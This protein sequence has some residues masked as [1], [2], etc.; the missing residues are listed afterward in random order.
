MINT[1]MAI[2]DETATAIAYPR[3]ARRLQAALLDAFILVIPL[4]FGLGTVLSGFDFSGGLKAALFASAVL[5]LEPGLVC[6]TGGTIGHH[7]L[8]LRIQDK[9]TG[10]NLNPFFAFIRFSL[11]LVLGWLSFVFILVTK[12]H[13]AL[14]DVFS[15]SVV[16]IRNPTGREGLGEEPEQ[17]IYL[18]EFEYPAWY[19]RVIAIV[20]YIGF[21]L[22]L[23][24]IL[25]AVLLSE[26][27][28]YQDRCSPSEDLLNLVA[29]LASIGASIGIFYFGWTGQLPGAR[30]KARTLQ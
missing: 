11:K 12:R 18:A 13:Q 15:N 23:L 26:E 25:F 29:S 21:M 30:R 22:L 27:C 17:E 1:G 7:A 24:G 4:F 20:F 9:R 10:S 16:T 6:T 19:R 14:H 5:I 2:H 28:L 3:L 8:G